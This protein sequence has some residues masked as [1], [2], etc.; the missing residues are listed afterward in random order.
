MS[1]A[2]R[3][4]TDENDPLTYATVSAFFLEMHEALRDG[5]APKFSGTEEMVMNFTFNRINRDK[6][7]RIL[8]KPNSKQVTL[9]SLHKVESND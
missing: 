3:Q 5:I 8:I 9:Y 7:M 6:D 4:I 2:V 1:V